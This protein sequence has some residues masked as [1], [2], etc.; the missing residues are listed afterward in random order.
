MSVHRGWRAKIRQVVRS[1]SMQASV[2]ES[3]QFESDTIWHLEPVQL[4]SHNFGDT[5]DMESAERVW[6][7]HGEEA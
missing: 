6:R 5:H 7:Q 4:L 2:Y 3:A 1:E